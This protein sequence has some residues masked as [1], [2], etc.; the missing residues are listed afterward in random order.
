MESKRAPFRI[1]R[2]RLRWFFWPSFIRLPYRGLFFYCWIIGLP[3]LPCFLIYS[4]WKVA[5]LQVY[6]QDIK[7]GRLHQFALGLETA[8]CGEVFPL[9]PRQQSVSQMKRF[10]NYQLQK[11][12]CT[13]LYLYET[14]CSRNLSVEVLL[15]LLLL[16]F[17]GET[18]A[19]DTLEG[20]NTTVRIEGNL[21]CRCVGAVWLMLYLQ[22]VKR[23]RRLQRR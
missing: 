14:G 9:W 17:K 20:K 5:Y 11:L 23:R 8:K 21:P 4:F 10:S 15:S 22:R 7:F 16:D 6:T 12:E 2:I 3:H 18:W 1:I 13:E 19:Q